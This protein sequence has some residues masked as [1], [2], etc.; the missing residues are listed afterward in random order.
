MLTPLGCQE[1]RKGGESQLGSGYASLQ[2]Y[3]QVGVLFSSSFS[4]MRSV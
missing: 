4:S 1:E 2:C 3:S